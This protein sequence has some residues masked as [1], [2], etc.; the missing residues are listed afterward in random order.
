[1]GL[2][3][4]NERFVQIFFSST[5]AIGFDSG[6]GGILS[7]WDSIPFFSSFERSVC[8]LFCDVNKYTGGGGG[9]CLKDCF[10]V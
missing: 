1:M 5:V 2:F 8:S 3:Q 4:S 7:L 6:M 9:G 10:S